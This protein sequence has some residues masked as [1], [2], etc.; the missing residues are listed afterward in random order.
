MIMIWKSN[1]NIRSEYWS[2]IAT[3]SILKHS[4][5][6]IW[7]EYSFYE[8]QIWLFKIEIGFNW[9]TCWFSQLCEWL[10]LIPLWFYYGFL[11]WLSLLLGHYFV[12]VVLGF[13]K[14]WF[15]ITKVLK[16][17]QILN[18]FRANRFHCLLAVL[19]DRYMNQKVESVNWSRFYL[20]Y[21]YFW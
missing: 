15:K 13:L 11:G 5:C 17:I 14:M 2:I 12:D 9:S 16:F 21:N 4:F 18:L 20:R 1:H 19:I 7:S 8:V 6:F 3:S 10:C